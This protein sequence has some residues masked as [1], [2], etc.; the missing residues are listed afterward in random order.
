MNRDL[1]FSLFKNCIVV[2]GASRATICDLQ[3]SSYIFITNYLADL[4][5]TSDKF[6]IGGLLNNYRDVSENQLEVLFNQLIEFNL[7]HYY[8]NPKN[9]PE[10][11]PLFKSPYDIHDCII[12]LSD[13]N[14]SQIKPILGSLT[15][16]GCQIIELRSYDDFS[17][18]K[19]EVILSL[20]ETTRI[21][22][23]E[24]YLKYSNTVPELSY[25]NL[26]S[27][28]PILDTF[29]IHSALVDNHKSIGASNIVYTTQCI[30]SAN[31]CGNISKEDFKINLPFYLQG[32]ETN[33]CLYKKISIKA[34]GSITN[35][36]SL[37]KKY[38]NIRDKSIE[39]V[40]KDPVFKE[41]WGIN[42]AQVK[43]CKDCEFRFICSDCRAFVNSKY[44]KPKKCNYDPYTNEYLD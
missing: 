6:T 19:V 1:Y 38:G 37:E 33:T 27:K 5:L 3:N 41:L 43:V 11:N 40:I 13:I 8:E 32:L 7:G 44:D 14:L 28:Y 4:L 25:E 17:I 15:D 34:D 42:K 2:K 29:L 10:I 24:L 23:A 18:E 20:L 31:C 35:C 16:L 36:P 26:V 30:S 9:F 21:R 39:K 12:E 22:S